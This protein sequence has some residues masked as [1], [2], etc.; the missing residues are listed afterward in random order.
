[1]SGSITAAA[2]VFILWFI[3]GGLID[4]WRR[5]VVFRPDDFNGNPYRRYCRLC[6]QCQ[7]FYEYPWGGS[8]WWEAQGSIENEHC[9]CHDY[10]T[11][12]P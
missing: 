5:S 12:V 9:E 7:T 11:Y 6:G 3:G 1:M 8:G 4:G 10:A 2:F